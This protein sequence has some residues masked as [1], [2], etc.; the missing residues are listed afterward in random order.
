MAHYRVSHPIDTPP[1]RTELHG[2]SPVPGFAVG[3]F[4]SALLPRDL[5]GDR[6]QPTRADCWLMRSAS[7]ATKS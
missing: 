1:V 4:H 2:P 7:R 3:R 6:L 5:R